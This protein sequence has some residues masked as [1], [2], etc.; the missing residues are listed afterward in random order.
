M[1]KIELID[2]FKMLERLQ[3]WNTDDKQDS[4]LYSFALARIIEQPTVEAIPKADYENRLKADLKAILVDLQ[5]EIREHDPGCGWD[6][7][8]DKNVIDCIIQ[9]RI[10]SLKVEGEPRESEET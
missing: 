9:Q 10:N 5:L 3:E 6:G 4:F 7:Y 1:G 8:A 2:R